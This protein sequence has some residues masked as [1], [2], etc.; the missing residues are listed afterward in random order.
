M[1]IWWALMCKKSC[2]RKNGL[3]EERILRFHVST[4][5]SVQSLVFIS[6]DVRCRHIQGETWTIIA[7]G[8]TVFVNWFRR[9]AV[10]KNNVIS[11]KYWW[12]MKLLA[13]L[14]EHR[15]NVNFRQSSFN[16]N[17]RPEPF[18]YSFNTER[19]L[20]GNVWINETLSKKRAITIHTKTGWYP[21]AD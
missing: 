9:A 5:C 4:S 13:W 17:L 7:F 10:Q 18:I 15:Q 21:L 6:V 19:C 3:K 2:K 12:N 14:L 11:L 16:C 20:P 8:G 1:N